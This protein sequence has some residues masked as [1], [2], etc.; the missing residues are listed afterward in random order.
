MNQSLKKKME[1]KQVLIGLSIIVVLLAGIII[2][3]LLK[4]AKSPGGAPCKC[5]TCDELGCCKDRECPPIPECPEG[6][7][8]PECPKPPTCPECKCPSCPKNPECPAPPECP[9]CQGGEDKPRNLPPFVPQV[10]PIKVTEDVKILPPNYYLSSDKGA[11]VSENGTHRVYVKDKKLYRNNIAFL[12]HSTG[13]NASAEYLYMNP[14]GQLQLQNANG[15]QDV[16]W[17]DIHNKLLF[18][19]AWP[20][21]PN[22]YAKLGND[23]FLSVIAPDGKVMITF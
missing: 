12:V 3:L 13:P 7:E 20:P 1:L 23:G 22:S 5:K 2:Y 10:A 15:S 21:V 14:T 11:L 4:P 8:C 18:G 19:A 9:P 17:P 6:G 16:Q